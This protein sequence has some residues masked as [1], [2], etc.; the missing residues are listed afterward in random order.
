MLPLDC[1]VSARS[2][3]TF[4]V[5]LLRSTSFMLQTP[6]CRVQVQSVGCGFWN[7]TLLRYFTI[8][9][10]F[11]QKFNVSLHSVKLHD[12]KYPPLHR[13]TKCL[14]Y[15]AMTAF[16]YTSNL[17]WIPFSSW[18]SVGTPGYLG[19]EEKKKQKPTSR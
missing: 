1:K 2:H 15:C 18:I 3:A 14:T 7:H 5:E 12:L 4:V 17:Y 11:L 9:H 10:G 13:S 6:F 19:R 16:S 8:R